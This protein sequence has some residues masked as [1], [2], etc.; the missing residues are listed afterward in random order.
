M[1]SRRTFF[2]NILVVGTLS[3]GQNAPQTQRQTG[4]LLDDVYLRHL[5]G[6]SDHPERPER[7][8]AIRNGLDRSGL[9]KS[10]YRITPRRVTDE[11][12]AFVHTRAY[13]DVVR[14]EL[15]NL[16]GPAN[17]STGDT[18]VSPGSLE[19]AEYAAGGV[20]NAVDA[21][22]TK[23]VKNAFCAVRPPGHHATPTRGMGFCI[24]NNVAIAAR[25]AQQKRGAKRVLIVDWDYHHGNGTQDTFYED[26]SVFVFDTHHYGA[27]PGTGS[28]AETGAGKGVGTKLN[29]AMPVGSGDAQFLEAFKT[30]LVPAARKFKPDFI[31]ISA[32]FDGMRDDVLGQFD[33]TPQGFAAMTRVVVDLANQLCQ[34]RI[35]SV[36]EGGYRLDGLSESVVAHVKTLQSF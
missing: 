21:V 22:M 13:V 10:L 23:R 33:I 32:G 15:S 12:L 19:A 4:L 7:L 25:Y 34:G 6:V 27:Y 18:L 2:A 20:L 11:E 1:L 29:L 28:P 3:V 24:Y 8:T 31:L 16:R 9:L 14:K 5:A 35:V 30:R 26:D 36:L 17:L